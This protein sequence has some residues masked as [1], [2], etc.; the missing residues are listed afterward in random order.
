MICRACSGVNMRAR[1]VSFTRW[2]PPSHT[3]TEDCWIRVVRAKLP[4]G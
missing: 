4:S 3:G 1:P 2:S